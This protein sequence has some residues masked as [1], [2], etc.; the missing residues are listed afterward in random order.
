MVIATSKPEALDAAVTDMA[1]LADEVGVALVRLDGLHARG[2]A[3]TLPGGVTEV[4]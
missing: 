4:D 3:A 2:V 1:R